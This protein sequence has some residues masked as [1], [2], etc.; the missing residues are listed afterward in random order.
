[1]DTIVRFMFTLICVLVIGLPVQAQAPASVR[2]V[3]IV[4]INSVDGDDSLARDAT[5]A[6]RNIVRASS[7]YVLNDTDVMETQ[8]VLTHSCEVLDGSCLDRVLAEESFR[9]VD[10]VV[11]GQMT[12]A[13]EGTELRMHLELSLYD[14]AEREVAQRYT[15]DVTVEELMSPELRNGHAG[16]WFS[17]LAPTPTPIAAGPAPP[18]VGGVSMSSGDFE[19][20]GWTLVG[21]AAALGVIAIITGATVLNMNG[22]TRFRDYRESW[23][24]SSGNVCDLARNDPSPDGMY[25]LS[26]CGSASSFELAT[27]IL[28]TVAA[29]LGVGGVLAIWHPGTGEQ[30]APGVTLTPSFGTGH[31]AVNISGTF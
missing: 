2:E 8:L 15:I 13:G 17:E 26:H 20:L 10:F 25:A 24:A 5:S 4:G 14:V 16:R 27:P 23:S 6:L 11:Y 7:G 28:W 22:D 9:E 21:T 1:M 29:A 19:I 3:L 12:R 18:S 31:A 30:R